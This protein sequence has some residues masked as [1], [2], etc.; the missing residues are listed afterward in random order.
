[1]LEQGNANIGGGRRERGA[2]EWLGRRRS[3]IHGVFM[4]WKRAKELA[5]TMAHTAMSYIGG[6]G[7]EGREGE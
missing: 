1:M 3:A 2:W 5:L 4:N 6:G 7:G